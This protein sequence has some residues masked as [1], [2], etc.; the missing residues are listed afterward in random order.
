M[1]YKGLTYEVGERV[2]NAISDL[3]KEQGFQEDK[4]WGE[5]Y[6]P[7]PPGSYLTKYLYERW[8]RTCKVSGSWN[9]EQIDQF[10]AL[11]WNKAEDSVKK[12]PKK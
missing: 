3:L 11:F 9:K 12:L 4:K 2:R 7:Y 8:D 5:R 10:S 1:T 6:R